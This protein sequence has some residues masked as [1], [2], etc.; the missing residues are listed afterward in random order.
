MCAGEGPR[1]ASAFA[2]L[3]VLGA[4]ACAVLVGSAWP[5]PAGSSV[6]ALAEKVRTATVASDAKE[7]A[8]WCDRFCFLEH[9]HATCDSCVQPSFASYMARVKASELRAREGWGIHIP[10]DAELRKQQHAAEQQRAALRR[11]GAGGSL[12]SP[13]LLGAFSPADVATAAPLQALRQVGARARRAVRA[14]PAAAASAGGA[15]TREDVMAAM[16]RSEDADKARLIND[17]RRLRR[18]R[19]VAAHLKWLSAHSRDVRAVLLAGQQ[20]ADSRRGSGDTGGSDRPDRRAQQLRGRRASGGGR[21][22]GQALVGE[23]AERGRAVGGGGVAAPPF[24]E[25]ME[26]ARHIVGGHTQA[27]RPR[28]DVQ[29]AASVGASNAGRHGTARHPRRGSVVRPGPRSRGPRRRLP[30]AGDFSAGWANGLPT[31][32]GVQ[33]PAAAATGEHGGRGGRKAG[34]RMGGKTPQCHTAYD[35]FGSIF[36]ATAR[37]S[38]QAAKKKVA[39]KK[40]TDPRA[41]IKNQGLGLEK[42]LFRGRGRGVRAPGHQR[43]NPLQVM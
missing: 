26:E 9:T 6:T 10:S 16:Q 32:L 7:H 19:A 24:R 41:Y 39:N 18:D 8:S 27:V 1:A 38:R 28:G 29:S 35:C 17:E 12:H 23:A 31:P 4:A 34:V 25:E 36:G 21:R 15:Q 13:R 22:R 40:I 30:L 20:P 33:A 3:L 43:H 42:W 11:P 14:G 5:M 37:G 2:R